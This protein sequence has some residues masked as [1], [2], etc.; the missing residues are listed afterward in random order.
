MNRAL[1]LLLV[2]ALAANL[3]LLAPGPCLAQLYFGL[4]G[5]SPVVH[6][7]RTEAGSLLLQDLT[8]E[9]AGDGVNVTA[10]QVDISDTEF[11]AGW[12]VGGRLGYWLE[13]M[14]FLAVEAEVYSSFPRISD[15]TLSFNTALATPATNG[16]TD[17]PVDIREADMEVLTL[18][19]NLIARYPHSV[20]QP[21]G[22]AGVGLV[23]GAVDDVRLASDATF[24]VGGATF[25]REGG[26]KIF[27]LQGK[28][29]WVWALQ[30][31]GG[32]RGFISDNVALFVEYKY[33]NTKFEFQPVEIDYDV[34]HLIGGIEFY[35][36]PGVV[37]K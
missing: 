35:L 36:G 14:P 10:L 4:Y 33:L 5:G 6:D 11:D 1:P 17:V 32:L 21:Y 20:I 2:A 19:L 3:V 15:Q 13:S 26:K 25:T 23:R 30:V 37:E 24:S 31:V 9:A 29:D 28:D 18:G 8:N 16:I 7:A 34:S 27:Q 12:L 22:G